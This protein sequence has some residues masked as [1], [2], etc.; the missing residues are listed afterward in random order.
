VKGRRDP[1]TRSDGVG[2]VSDLMVTGLGL[3]GTSLWFASS[4]SAGVVFLSELVVD[5]SEQILGKGSEK[6]PSEV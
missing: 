6:V 5:L 1:N 4:R 3:L 2:R